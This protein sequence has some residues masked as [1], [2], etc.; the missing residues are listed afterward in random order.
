MSWFRNGFRAFDT[1]TT[2]V[3]VESSRI[4]SAALVGSDLP[5]VAHNG[6][7]DMTLLFHEVTR[8]TDFDATAL[9]NVPLLDTFT[10]HYGVFRG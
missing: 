2:G 3:E 4:M 8:H 1:E 7:F 10:M 6:T 5:V 9:A